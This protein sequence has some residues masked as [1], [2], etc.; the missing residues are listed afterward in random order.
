MPIPR[1]RPLLRLGVALAGLAIAGVAQAQPAP[2][3][4]LDVTVAAAG[5]FDLDPA[6]A[7]GGRLAAG[8]DGTLY[9][10]LYEARPLATPAAT[11]REARIDLLALAPDGAVKRRRTLPVGHGIGHKEFF[12]NALGVAVTRTGDIAVFVSANDPSMIQ[13]RRFTDA[14]LFRL[15][16]DFRL[17]KTARLGPPGAQERTEALSFYQPEFYLPTRDDALMLGGGFGPGPLVWWVGK[18]GFDGTRLWQD[19]GRGI[20]ESTAALAPRPD[21]TWISVVREMATG[22]S[23]LVL[24]VR[25]YSAGGKVLMRTALPQIPSSAA[26]A[27]VPGGIAFITPADAPARR[28]EW[29]LIDDNGR[30]VVRRAAW[31]FPVTLSAIADGDG[32]AAI[33]ADGN[34]SA[35]PGYVVRTDSSGTIRWRSPPLETTTIVRTPDGQVVA[36]SPVGEDRKAVRIVRFADP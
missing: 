14:T 33:V 20:P 35:A 23:G 32:V 18:Y 22:P 31:P 11:H 25:R 5:G 16:P 2:R 26:V 12:L 29:I 27:I 9:L 19:R 8:S 28:A 7:A 1:R 24:A 10:L 4:T 17:R 36:L 21:G 13:R 6:A 15:A 30:R 3:V 34:T